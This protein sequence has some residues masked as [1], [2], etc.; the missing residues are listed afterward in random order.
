MSG[1]REDM[2]NHDGRTTPVTIGIVQWTLVRLRSGGGRHVLGYRI[3]DLRGRTSSPIRSFDRAT[4]TATTSSGN[5]YVFVG[6]A[7]EDGFDDPVILFWLAEHDLSRR[8]VE[9]I[10]MDDL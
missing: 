8:D 1:R 6:D 2:R 7:S 4:R 3:A 10:G 5:R 9:I